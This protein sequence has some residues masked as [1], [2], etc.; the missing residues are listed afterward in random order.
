MTPT[1]DRTVRTPNKIYAPWSAATAA[2]LNDYQKKPHLIPALT[3]PNGHSTWILLT[4]GPDGW[5]CPRHYC[6]HR[7]NWAWAFMAGPAEPEES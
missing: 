1:T 7:Q 6:G 3:C 4:A 5:R 2:A